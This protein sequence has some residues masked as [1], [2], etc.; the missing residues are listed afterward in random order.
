M[1]S[2]FIWETRMELKSF[3]INK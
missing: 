1:Y 3:I 2:V